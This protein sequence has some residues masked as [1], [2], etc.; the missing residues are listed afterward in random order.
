MLNR[1]S[2]LNCRNLTHMFTFL[3]S[4]KAFTLTSKNYKEINIK[5]HKNS[6][7]FYVDQITT[8][9]YSPYLVVNSNK[10]L[11]IKISVIISVKKIY[12]VGYFK[13]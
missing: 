6:H 8:V 3:S 5:I 9:S 11:I 1:I 7:R 2:S 13:N 4:G 10:Y 12:Y